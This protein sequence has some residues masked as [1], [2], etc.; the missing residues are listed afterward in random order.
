MKSLQ[1]WAWGK[2]IIPD[3]IRKAKRHISSIYELQCFNK[4][5]FSKI[6]KEKTVLVTG[7]GLSLKEDVEKFE[8]WDIPHD[9][10]CCNRSLLF[11]QRPV[12]HWAAVDSEECM[13]LAQYYNPDNGHFLRHSIG[14]CGGFDVYWTAKGTQTEFGRRLWIGNTGYFAILCAIGMGYEKIIV[15]GMPLDRERHWYDPEGTEGPIWLGDTYTIWLDFRTKCL[16]SYKA[17]SLSGYSAA[18][19][20]EAK[21]EWL[22]IQN[23]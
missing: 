7:D 6:C 23:P 13:W 8:S 18:I 19:L 21:K 16:N 3:E 4:V 2:K 5:D 15:A 17:R 20:G 10:F 9:L 1:T 12:N 22:N 11:F 14:A